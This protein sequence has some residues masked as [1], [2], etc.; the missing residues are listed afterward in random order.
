MKTIFSLGIL[1][2]LALPAVGEE[3]V[4]DFQTELNH[5]TLGRD[6]NMVMLTF[7][8][9]ELSV[10]NFRMNSFDTSAVKTASPEPV[11]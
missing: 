3:F 6:K 4:D 10:R 1:I 5:A 8:D 11:K 7:A 2:L 9:G